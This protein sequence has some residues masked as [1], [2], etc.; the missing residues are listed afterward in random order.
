MK[1]LRP[2]LTSVIRVGRHTP[3]LV[4]T[5]IVLT[6]ITQFG[7]TGLSQEQS[8]IVSAVPMLMM[9][10]V[11][12]VF[13][14]F[15]PT[16]NEPSTKGRG[17]DADRPP[18]WFMAWA[19][20]VL[21]TAF[22]GVVSTL[23]APIYFLLHIEYATLAALV[24]AGIMIGIAL[25]FVCALLAFAKSRALLSRGRLYADML[26]ANVF[27]IP[28]LFSEALRLMPSQHQYQLLFVGGRVPRKK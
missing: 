10:L 12:R 20:I 7:T 21:L 18:S 3:T 8:A 24:T 22:L 19:A 14:V 16:A 28:R 1:P 17:S 25:V 4:I 2:L 26:I 5:A 13:I 23:C 11:N 27:T 15:F 9:V 6:A